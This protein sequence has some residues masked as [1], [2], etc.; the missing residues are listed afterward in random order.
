ML[1]TLPGQG[2]YV[3]PHDGGL[4]ADVLAGEGLLG[5]GCRRMLDHSCV[6][7]ASTFIRNDKINLEE[8]SCQLHIAELR[9]LA[10]HGCHL[11]SFAICR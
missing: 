1:A 4:K 3:R 8:G 2:V 6:L 11:F 5:H 9:A 10:S 7:R